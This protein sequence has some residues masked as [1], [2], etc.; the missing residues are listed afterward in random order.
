MTD[1]S[2]PSIGTVAEE[3]ARLISAIAAMAHSTGTTT[4]AYDPS[5][6]AG[7]PAQDPAS[8]VGASAG[9]PG[10]DAPPVCSACGGV[11]DGT[12]V[13]CTLCPLCQGIALLRSV[14]PETVDRLA[15]FASAVAATL[16]DMATQSRSSDPGSGSGQGPGSP[17]DGAT[18]QDIRVDDGDEG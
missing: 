2:Q 13:A 3:A 4:S 17:S 9:D 6:Y 8:P 5:P 15:D 1:Q 18:V 12:P 16:K 7:E 14:R 10:P 11:N